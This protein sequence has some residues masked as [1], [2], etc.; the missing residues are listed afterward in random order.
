MKKTGKSSDE[1]RRV[2]RELRRVRGYRRLKEQIVA[3]EALIGSLWERATCTV[4]PANAEP[5]S[6]GNGGDKVGAGAVRLAQEKETLLRMKRREARLLRR[7]KRVLGAMPQEEQLARD[8][9]SFYV[10]EGMSFAQMEGRWKYLY[11]QRYL[12]QVM[13][14]ALEHAL[15]GKSENHVVKK[16]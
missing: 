8:V 2:M 12:R 5:G 14:R 6:G 3:K 16:V 11:S 1:N 7:M 13:C 4:V 15:C 10:F 9:F